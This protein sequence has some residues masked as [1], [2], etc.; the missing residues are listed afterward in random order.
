MDLPVP[1]FEWHDSA[2]M[3]R[4]WQR[5]YVCLLRLPNVKSPLQHPHSGT[6]ELAAWS[7][8]LL[9]L[10]SLAYLTMEDDAQGHSPYTWITTL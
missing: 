5:I 9:P 3:D 4:P 8:L 1:S 7:T 6:Q 2:E 10:A